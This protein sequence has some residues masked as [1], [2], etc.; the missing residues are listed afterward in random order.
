MR[1]ALPAVALVQRFGVAVVAAGPDLR[2]AD[3]RIEGAIVHAMPV[4]SATGHLLFVFTD[5]AAK[6]AEAAIRVLVGAKVKAPL[7]VLAA[8]KGRHP[9]LFQF[10][11]H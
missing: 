4:T 6:N 7:L 9:L 5:Q 2:A 10:L 8:A 11:V 1:R 3:P